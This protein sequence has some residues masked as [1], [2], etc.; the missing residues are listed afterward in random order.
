LITIDGE[1]YNFDI[2]IDSSGVARGVRSRCD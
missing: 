2:V 1:E